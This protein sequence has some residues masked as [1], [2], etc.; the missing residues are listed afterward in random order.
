MRRLGQTR[1]LTWRIDSPASRRSNTACWSF[2]RYCLSGAMQAGSREQLHRQ[3]GELPE[4]RR[5]QHLSNVHYSC[6]IGT[7]GSF[8]VADVPSGRYQLTVRIPFKHIGSAASV[9]FLAASQEVTVPKAGDP[10][11]RQP[12]DLG[13]LNLEFKDTSEAIPIIT[14][15]VTVSGTVTESD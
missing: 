9:R 7:D 2:H 4:V 5:N 1:R 6:R 15:T 8:R 14:G 10:R 11:D 13:M 3:W 12:H